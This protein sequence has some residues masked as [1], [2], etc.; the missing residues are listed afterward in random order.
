MATWLQDVRFGL[1]LLLRSPG[2]TLMAVA[3]LAI[4][5]GANT[6]IFSV[7]N[8]LILQPP[9]YR[10]PARLAVL[11]EYR[12]AGESQ[13]NIV[14]PG[15]FIHWREMNTSFED[16]SVV[17]ITA[18][19]TITGSGGSGGDAGA[20]EP[21][22]AN[23]QFVSASF[24]QLLGVPPQ[25]GR[26]FTAAEDVPDLRV[27]VISDR[28]WKRRFGGDPGV[29]RRPLLLDG[30]AYTVTGVMPEGFSYL[31]RTVDLWRPVG[32]RPEA[33]TPRGRGVN[34]IGRLKP[35]VTAAQADRELKQ[36]HVEMARL[37]PR[38]NTGWSARVVPLQEEMTGEARPALLV[39]VGAVACVLLIACAN[40]ANLLL[41]RATTRQREMAVRAAL[42]AARGRLVRQMMAESLLLAFAGGAAGLALAWWG[43]RAVRLVVAERVPIA[44]LES[45]TIDGTV[46][47]FTIAAC[48]L[49]GLFFGLVPALTASGT[50]LSE[51]LKEGGRTGSAAR[52]ARTR[53]TFVVAEIA[54]ALV[55]LVGA[56]LLVRSFAKLLAVD[57][58]FDLNTVSMRIS[59][60]SSRYA[61]D[62]KPIQ[63][64]QQLFDRIDALPGVQDAGAISFLPL[65]TFGAATGYVVADQP[66]PPRGQ[67]PTTEVRVVMRD[68]FK[69]MGVPLVRGRLFTTQED[70][71]PREPMAPQ[72]AAVLG[73]MPA[74]PALAA[75]AARGAGAGAANAGGSNARAPNAGAANP[76]GAATP[77]GSAATAAATPQGTIRSA[78]PNL[79]I[80][81]ETLARRH[82][83][84]QDP[85]GKRLRVSWGE[86]VESEVVGV[87]GDTR[88]RT[89]DTAARPT[90][91]WPHP[92]NAYRAMTLTIRGAGSPG[93]LSKAIVGLVRQQDPNLVVA[94][95]RTMEE[96]VSTSVA[97]QRLM[98]LF[99]AI[100]AV[101]AL[102]LAA[103]GIHGVIAYSVTQ[104]TQEIGIRMALGAQ[105]RDVLK[106]VVGHALL[107]AALGITIGGT[108]A[109]ML[110]RVMEGLLFD[111][112][113]L[114]PLTY[115]GV[116]LMLTAVAGLAA[117]LPGR[118]A[119]RVDP[120]IALRA[121]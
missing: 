34:V 3:A 20:G 81:N 27:V 46:L 37:F 104:R 57:P 60:P 71:T 97:R 48:L 117:W 35:G 72:T 43:V 106:M 108:A 31:D 109:L 105:A 84:G 5:I 76:S 77:G 101:A 75:A 52:G 85:I 55:L 59:L 26:P 14:S 24:F 50:V 2:F 89:L 87:V 39:L 30:V 118:R 119:T 92:Q 25:L 7:I 110:S 53:G 73:G 90:I 18:R 80:V 28:L 107:L 86:D 95:V 64:Y 82:W 33:R 47:M 103:V 111:I 67:W 63:F 19:Q 88:F 42:G 100:F 79:V 99:L 68:Y 11:W 10:D 91:Y 98:M 49:S 56:G 54:L 58:G 93:S 70:A 51:S 4:G 38:V 96:V 23:L 15:N 114:D 41:A 121:E 120:M 8:T 17:S 62:V 21:E 112:T 22:E 29:L 13:N 78:R 6:A 94:D 44:R 36:I 32:F 12:V 115:G 16:L 65:A 45:V 66:E 74:N 40:V 102:L 116:T 113:P 1:R 61:G 69:A 9:P 83:P